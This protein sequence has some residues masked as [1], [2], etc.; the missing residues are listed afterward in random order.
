[1]LDQPAMV[2][3]GGAAV[4]APRVGSGA[5]RRTRRPAASGG[6]AAALLDRAATAY[7]AL[8]HVPD[9]DATLDLTRRSVGGEP[10]RVAEGPGAGPAP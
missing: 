4:P 2:R 7:A 5:R 10:V 3:A 6:A 1:M 9:L 8:P